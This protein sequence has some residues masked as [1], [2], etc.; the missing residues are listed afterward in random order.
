MPLLQ[1]V[2]SGRSPEPEFDYQS[3][4]HCSKTRSLAPASSARLITSQNATAPKQGRERP[5]E[6]PRLITSQNATAPKRTSLE[7]CTS[8]S[9]ITSQN[10]T[11]PKQHS[12]GW[13][14]VVSLITSQNA[15]A[16]K[17]ERYRRDDEVV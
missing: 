13:Y 6:P 15:T 1:N 12:G 16:P 17:P 5:Q 14:G 11:A 4:C 8:E 2:L 3:E 7:P 10:A 9:L